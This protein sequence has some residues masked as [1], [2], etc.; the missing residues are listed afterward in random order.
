MEHGGESGNGGPTRPGSA[1]NGEVQMGKALHAQI[2]ALVQARL[3]YRSPSA[4]LCRNVLADL[5]RTDRPE[6]KEEK[7]VRLQRER[8]AKKQLADAAKAKRRADAEAAREDKRR[9]RVDAG[10]D[11]A[12]IAEEERMQK[13][14]SEASGQRRRYSALLLTAQSPLKGIDRGDAEW[15]EFKVAR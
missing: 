14:L 11:P 10:E 13:L 7:K 1:K 15:Q 8:E 6:T 5:G 9:R 2:N 12:Q 3:D 4:M